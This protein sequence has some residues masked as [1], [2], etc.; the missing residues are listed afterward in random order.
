MSTFEFYRKRFAASV[1]RQAKIRAA[2]APPAPGRQKRSP[3][4]QVKPGPGDAAAAYALKILGLCEKAGLTSSTTRDVMRAKLSPS[5]LTAFSKLE[6][7]MLKLALVQRA[8]SDA[9][10]RVVAQLNRSNGHQSE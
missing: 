2:K 5:E 6:T 7:P 9:W 8:S 4:R 3:G 10:D 1:A